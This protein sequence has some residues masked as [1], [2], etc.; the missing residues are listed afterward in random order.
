MIWVLIGWIS[1]PA[2]DLVF[3]QIWDFPCIREIRPIIWTR[4]KSSRSYHCDR[5]VSQLLYCTDLLTNHRCLRLMNCSKCS[6]EKIQM[7]IPDWINSPYWK[8]SFNV[9]SFVLSSKISRS[10]RIWDWGTHP[11]SHISPWP[12]RVLST[13]A[14]LARL[15]S[16][17]YFVD[18]RHG[19]SALRVQA[20][21]HYIQSRNR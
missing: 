11:F 9:L 13:A 8:A 7:A 5:L 12:F 19:L 2:H 10:I 18:G 21:F 14:K 1:R 17:S 16:E 3:G 15:N 6:H 20:T 4:R